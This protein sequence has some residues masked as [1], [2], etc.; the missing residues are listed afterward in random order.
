M[1]VE[2]SADKAFRTRFEFMDR[3]KNQPSK[4]IIVVRTPFLFFTFV[5]KSQIGK[6]KIKNTKQQKEEENTSVEN[7]IK[8]LYYI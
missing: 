7:K 4:S 1:D 2:M 6:F 5:E 8:Y 3:S